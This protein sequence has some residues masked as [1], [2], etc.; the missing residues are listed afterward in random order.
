[1]VAEE[2]SK[3]KGGLPTPNCDTLHPLSRLM[4]W[5]QGKG[6]NQWWWGLWKMQERSPWVRETGQEPN[7]GVE[8][9]WR[10]GR[11]SPSCQQENGQRSRTPVPPDWWMCLG[12]ASLL[13]SAG[14]Y[15]F[16][17]WME[18]W[19]NW[20]QKRGEN[21]NSCL[22]KWKKSLRGKCSAADFKAVLRSHLRYLSSRLPQPRS[23]LLV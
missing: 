7:T 17:S 1:M 18:E 22:W 19:D 4:S 8:V 13:C 23:A 16:S 6:N 2:D 12:S 20:F 3:V 10:Q 11:S 14:F 21:V 5:I 9:S 15:V